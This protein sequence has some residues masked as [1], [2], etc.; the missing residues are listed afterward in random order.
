MSNHPLK[1]PSRRFF[2]GSIP[3]IGLIL[4][5]TAAVIFFPAASQ[6]DDHDEE[7]IE[8]SQVPDVVSDEL[9]WLLGKVSVSKSG[10]DGKGAESQPTIDAGAIENLLEFVLSDKK[11]GLYHAD[12]KKFSKSES[13]YYE[14][15][16]TN[17]LDRLLEMI[18]NPGI[19][20]SFLAP[21]SMR[22]STWLKGGGKN[23]A[24]SVWKDIISRREPFL[25]QGVEHVVNT[26]DQF[27]GG[28]Y[29]YNLNRTMAM[30]K[31]NGKNV[32]ISLSRQP[33][34]SEVGKR[35]FVLGSDDD[36]NYLYSGKKGLAKSGIEWV[37]S[38]MYDSR[39]VAIL[40]ETSPG[41]ARWAIFKWVKAGWLR[42]NVVKR[43]HIYQG[44][45]RYVKTFRK[46]IESPLL[47]DVPELVA[48]FSNIRNLSDESLKTKISV[49]LRDLEKKYGKDKES[50]RKLSK[51]MPDK[52]IYLSKMTKAEMHS[53]LFLEYIKRIF[54]KKNLS[55]R[56]IVPSQGS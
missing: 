56:P 14:F 31:H 43:R 11:D 45:Q 7:K 29:E 2:S 42:A 40:Y 16:I 28:Y 24:P 26:P 3:W 19:P 48:A 12:R 9:A 49:Y 38:Y 17:Q 8:S 15:D 36:W 50:A 10:S 23:M 53:I 33:K 20:G 51:G 5:L 32:F 55:N 41:K 25:V 18:H 27:S 37:K 47:P 6:A 4:V 35:G 52:E 54:N 44:I 21:S 34:V 13:A 1:N 22:I 39:T 30:V 46:I